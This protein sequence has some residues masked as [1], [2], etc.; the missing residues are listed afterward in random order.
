MAEAVEARG[1]EPATPAPDGSQPVEDR[2]LLRSR[3]LAVKILISGRGP[4]VGDRVGFSW[5]I[6]FRGSWLGIMPLDFGFVCVCR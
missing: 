6:G 5:C 1:G 3:Y 4:R 2:R